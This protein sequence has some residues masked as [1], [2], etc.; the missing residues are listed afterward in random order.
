MDVGRHTEH[1]SLDPQ[2]TPGRRG[3][4]LACSDARCAE[5]YG[6]LR[7]CS[8]APAARAHPCKCIKQQLDP[9]SAR[10]RLLHAPI[11][12]ARNCRL[13]LHDLRVI[14]AAIPCFRHAPC[15]RFLCFSQ[16]SAYIANVSFCIHFKRVPVRVSF[17]TLVASVP[18][19]ESQTAEHILA[20]SASLFGLCCQSPDTHRSVARVRTKLAI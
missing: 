14:Q 1:A 2:R 4:R 15:F 5:P 13:P 7:R 6:P 9:S 20:A 10:S 17:N 16:Q 11:S 18:A 12:S 19:P 8:S 3:R